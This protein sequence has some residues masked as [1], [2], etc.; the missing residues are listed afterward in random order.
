MTN[1]KDLRNEMTYGTTV[2]PILIQKLTCTVLLNN[3]L[4]VIQYFGY[5]KVV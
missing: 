2:Y 3:D 1:I 4:I 5:M